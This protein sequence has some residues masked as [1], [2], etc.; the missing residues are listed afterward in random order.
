LLVAASVGFSLGFACAVPL[1]AFATIAALTLPRREALLFTGAV[2]LANQ[3]AGFGVLGYP[4]DANTIAWGAV[5][6]IAA[7]LAVIAGHWAAGGRR[8]AVIRALTAF[9]AAFVVYEAVLFIA[10]VAALGAVENFSPAIVGY[11]LALNAV[12]LV[13]LYG[14]NLIAA[15]AGVPGFGGPRFA[16]AR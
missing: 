11:V 12:G 2:W 7:L 10:A 1:A 16:P 15:R 4:T 8:T 14:L 3:A 9:A 13:V 5:M 6:G